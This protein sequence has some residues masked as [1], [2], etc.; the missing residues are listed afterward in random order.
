MESYFFAMLN[1]NTTVKDG[2]QVAM[3]TY[4]HRAK[5]RLGTEAECKQPRERTRTWRN[6]SLGL[7]TTVVFVQNAEFKF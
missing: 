1:T 3:R 2:V 7:H 5:T 6:R 4:P